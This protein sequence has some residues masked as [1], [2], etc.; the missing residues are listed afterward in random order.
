MKSGIV[1]GTSPVTLSPQQPINGLAYATMIL[2]QLG[3][4]IDNGKYGS[5]LG[6]L[7]DI[8]GLNYSEIVK[9]SKG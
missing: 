2:R 1:I 7:Y 5:S 3:Y 4:T 6:I 8:G 9:D